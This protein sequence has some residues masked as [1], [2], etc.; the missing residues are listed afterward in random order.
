M[1]AAAFMLVQPAKKAGIKVPPD[2]ETYDVDEYPH[3]HAY[4]VMQVGAPMPD[5]SAHWSNAEVIAT[6]PDDRIREV[7][8]KQLREEF[9]FRV[10]HSK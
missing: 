1:I 8:P 4:I 6:V 5:P 9:G 10:G 3:W 7:T 2:P